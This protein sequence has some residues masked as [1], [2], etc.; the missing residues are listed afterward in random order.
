MSICPESLRRR[1]GREL[2][3]RPQRLTDDTAGSHVDQA[4]QG[5]DP[6]RIV[7]GTAYLDPTVGGPHAG[8]TG[9]E[10]R[11]ALVAG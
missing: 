8:A 11:F 10:D 3:N 7:P 6:G 1:P 4:L 5:G 9:T 2:M